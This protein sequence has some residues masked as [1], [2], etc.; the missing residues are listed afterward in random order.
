MR[1][2]FFLRFMVRYSVRYIHHAC[3]RCLRHV[4]NMIFRVLRSYLFGRCWIYL[5]ERC[6][7]EYDH[8]LSETIAA[9]LKCLVSL[10]R[11][12]TSDIVRFSTSIST[13]HDFYFPYEWCSFS[14][15]KKALDRISQF[16]RDFWLRSRYRAD[17]YL[18]DP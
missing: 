5:L 13:W 1:L 18:L 6:E 12:L 15:N 14:S 17:V 2:L 3:S 4:G 9:F 10:R 7:T 16:S 8:N 11:C